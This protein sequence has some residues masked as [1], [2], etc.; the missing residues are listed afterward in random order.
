[1]EDGDARESEALEMTGKTVDEAIDNGLAELGLER[2]E[3]AVEVLK[4]GRA[5]LFGIGGEPALVRL[6]PALIETP[7]G[8]DTAFA[9]E[10]LE[11]L[12]RLMQIE[13]TVT[14]RAPETA[15]DGVGLMKAVLDVHG[16]DLGVLI[17]RRGSTMAALQYL[18]NLTVS[19]R[20]RN[21]APFAV[22]IEGYRQRRE[23]SLR[24]L[25]FNMAERVRETGRPVTLE[26]MPANERRIVHITL[27]KDPTVS[28]SSVG[29]G[30]ARKVA[31]R[32][33]K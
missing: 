5:G 26:P 9:Q 15:G 19:R 17:G 10:T 2:H 23:K 18:V 27:A 8:E 32:V 14:V 28:T 30:D 29:D 6:S 3:V 13:A 31:I 22:D 1:M 4:E 21:N 24:E 20:F 16:D 11:T 12:L 33:R 25:A 7:E